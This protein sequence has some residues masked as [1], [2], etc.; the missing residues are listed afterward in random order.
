MSEKYFQ[1]D[2]QKEEKLKAR[3]EN[4]RCTK[5]PGNSFWQVDY[6]VLCLGLLSEISFS[7]F[8]A[9]TLPCFNSSH[10][11]TTASVL[12]KTTATEYAPG[13]DKGKVL[14]VVFTA[15]YLPFTLID[16]EET[17]TTWQSQ[18][19]FP[20]QVRQSYMVPFCCAAMPSTAEQEAVFNIVDSWFRHHMLKADL[21]WFLTSSA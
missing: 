20:S 8:F 14:P 10:I 11:S 17:K 1:E 15:F 12:G 18:T 16:S 4:G 21:Y 9:Y 2:K 13:T 7:N 5:Y 6:A 19:S 3:L